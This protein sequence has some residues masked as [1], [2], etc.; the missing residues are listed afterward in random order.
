MIALPSEFSRGFADVENNFKKVKPMRKLIFSQLLGAVQLT[1][2]FSDGIRETFTVTPLQAIVISL[3]N[4]ESKTGAVVTKS[5][6]SV[7]NVLKVTEDMG[8]Q[9]L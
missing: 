7:A 8:K 6:E 3:F 4:D 1:L 2:N 5:L 9:A